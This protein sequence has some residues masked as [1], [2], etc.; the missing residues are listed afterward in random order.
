MSPESLDPDIPR[1]AT[2]LHASAISQAISRGAADTVM[3][4]IEAAHE[5]GARI[6]YDTNFRP[7][8]WTAAQAAPVIAAA[9]AKADIVKTSAE[10]CEALLGLSGHEAIAAHF[11][12]LGSKA[13]I[14]T[15]GRDG[16]Y[17]ATPQAASRI[18]GFAV[19]AV[20][21][22]G[23]GDAFTGA[24]LAELSDGKPLLGA[25][26]FANA[27]A[28]LSTLGYGAIAPLPDRAAVEAFLT[29]HTAEGERQSEGN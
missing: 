16:S 24:L 2:F 19:E 8:L 3:A 4:A 14:L 10:D 22:T 25:A 5:A 7:R 6:S 17:V 9:A 1:G 11:L 26:R 13:V 29:A 27:A 20:D 23:A 21:A 28:A 18:P 12:G 15:L